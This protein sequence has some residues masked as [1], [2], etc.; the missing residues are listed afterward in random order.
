MLSLW[1]GWVTRG[2][3]GVDRKER[4]AENLIPF[5]EVDVQQRLKQGRS[6]IDTTN[7]LGLE[8]F[9]QLF[10]AR[11][12]GGEHGGACASR[13]VKAAEVRDI[14]AGND[15]RLDRDQSAIRLHNTRDGVALGM[16][17][18]LLAGPR[19]GVHND[20]PPAPKPRIRIDKGEIAHGIE[21]G[22]RITLKGRT[23]QNHVVLLQFIG[24][25][26]LAWLDDRFQAHLPK[27]IGEIADGIQIAG[28]E[29]DIF[30]V[31]LAGFGHE[32]RVGR[33]LLRK[34]GVDGSST[35]IA[36]AVRK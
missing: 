18:G 23:D 33:E 7:A 22:H 2:V 4:G 21:L 31:E 32:G 26:V 27:K 8:C 13:R 5:L 34:M 15:T 14:S 16:V 19:V 25:Q 10:H 3:Q 35:V 12:R 11:S 29:I 9:F 28:A 20:S 36:G 1:R 24:S 30:V 17:N 6:P